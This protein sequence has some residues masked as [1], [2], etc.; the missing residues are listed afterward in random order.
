MKC[1][2]CQS[3]ATSYVTELA[4]DGKSS[5]RVLCEVHARESG[6]HYYERPESKLT[7][8][9]VAANYAKS[10]RETAQTFRNQEQ[11]VPDRASLLPYVEYLEAAADFAEK[12][13]RVPTEDDLPPNPCA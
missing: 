7:E 5:S 13:R 3:H 12:H 6:Y 4:A 2:T 11:S 8:L 10:M 1:Q 9:E